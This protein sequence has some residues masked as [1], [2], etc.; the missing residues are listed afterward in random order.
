MMQD[1]EHHNAGK[2]PIG[3]WQ[4]TCVGDNI[5]AWKREDIGSDD[6]PPEILDVGRA[7]ADVQNWPVPV[8]NLI[9]LASEAESR[10][11]SVL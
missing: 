4:P 1:I 8:G 7:T 5:D 2:E 9:R 3:E 10:N 11:V 6:V